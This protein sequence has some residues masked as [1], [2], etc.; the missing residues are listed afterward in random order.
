MN[1]ALLLALSLSLA[2]GKICRVTDYG[3]LGDNT[4]EDTAA[5]QSALDAC[6]PGTTIF[7]APGKYLSRSLNLTGKSD[8]ELVIEGGATLVLWGDIDTW[9]TTGVFLDF[10]TNTA[11]HPAALL[12]SSSTDTTTTNI[13]IHGGGVIDGQG[14]RWWPFMK[15]RPRPRLVSM[16]KVV[17]FTLSNLTLLDSPG[18]NTN[19][20]GAFYGDHAHD[21]FIQCWEL[22]WVA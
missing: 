2:H 7:P 11:F 3:A 6:T 9:N 12:R 16:E 5:L 8:I 1:I 21:G 17:D 18:W 19:L 20:R 14:W 4:T 15:T 10:L 13:T 22:Q